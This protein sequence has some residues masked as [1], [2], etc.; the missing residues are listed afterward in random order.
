[1]QDHHKIRVWT[2][3]EN[4]YLEPEEG[5]SIL[6]LAGRVDRSTAEDKENLLDSYVIE[7]CT[8]LKDKNGKLSYEEDRILAKD[9]R[10]DKPKEYAIRFLNIESSDHGF[11]AF[12]LFEVDSQWEYEKLGEFYEFE[13]IGT[14]HDKEEDGITG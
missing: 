1:M 14:I 2:K 5:L 10:N 9:H 13:I 11:I 8:G 6:M 12:P 7:Q 4:K 3:L